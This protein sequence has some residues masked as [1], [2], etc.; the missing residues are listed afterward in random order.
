L[1]AY[2]IDPATGELAN[3]AFF[4]FNINKRRLPQVVGNFVNF[5]KG[6]LNQYVSKF[7]VI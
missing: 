4:N 7:A 6:K 2:S 3:Q 1:F 5:L